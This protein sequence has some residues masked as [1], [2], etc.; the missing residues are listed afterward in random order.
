MLCVHTVQ[1]QQNFI[2]EIIQCWLFM[3][4]SL[5]LFS[6]QINKIIRKSLSLG[7]QRG[8]KMATISYS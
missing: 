1:Q 6:Y 2:D 5:T 4:S 8:E 7:L 3:P